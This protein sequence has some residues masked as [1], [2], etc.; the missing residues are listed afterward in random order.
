MWQFVCTTNFGGIF[1]EWT[2]CLVSIVPNLSIGRRCK[3]LTYSKE[4]L[5]QIFAKGKE[6][7]GKDPARYRKDA[8]GNEIYRQSYGKES[9]MGWEVDHK[10]PK[11]NGGTNS[12]RNLQPLQSSENSSKGAKYPLTR[13]SKTILLFCQPSCRMAG[14]FCFE[15]C[16]ILLV[17]QTGVTHYLPPLDVCYY[18]FHKSGSFLLCC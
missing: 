7:P 8:C 2:I 1:A 10:N 18:H 15:S 6:I 12:M 16:N 5:D 17:T 14:F 11:D 3:A 13:R 9:P 4:Q